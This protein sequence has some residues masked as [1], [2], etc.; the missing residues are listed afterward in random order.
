[1]FVPPVLGPKEGETL[2]IIEV[3]EEVYEIA[4]GKLATVPD[5]YVTVMSQ[6][7]GSLVDTQIVVQMIPV[8][9]S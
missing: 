9:Y 2:V 6:T 5:E 3:A 7:L 1:M 8:N 4:D